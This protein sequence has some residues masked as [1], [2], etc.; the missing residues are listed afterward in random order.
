MKFRSKNMHYIFHREYFDGLELLRDTP[1]QSRIVEERNR[2]VFAFS[3]PHADLFAGMRELKN[4]HAFSLVTTYPGLLIGIGNPHDAKLEGA[5]KL[6]FSLDYVTGLPYIPGSSL[7]GM[8]R[9]RFPGKYTGEEKTEREILLGAYL[10][11]ADLDAGKLETE[12]FDGG[13]IF[14][15][16]FPTD[17]PG[18]GMLSSEYIT[19]H[20]EFQDPNP[21]SMM[22]IRPNVCFT[23]GF[24]LSDGAQIDAAQKCDLFRMLV[25]EAGIGAKTNV[26]FGRLVQTQARPAKNR[27]GY[28]PVQYERMNQLMKQRTQR[29]APPHTPAQS[30]RAPQIRAPQQTRSPQ[31]HR[32][33]QQSRPAQDHRTAQQS[34][35]AR[36]VLGKCPNCGAD[37]VSGNRF[38][39]CTGNCGFRPGR[40]RGYRKTVTDREYRKLL[41]GETVLMRGFESQ[42]GDYDALVRLKGVQPPQTDRN[43]GQTVCYGDYQVERQL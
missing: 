26:G 13:D 24:L 16:V 31:D 23:F 25:M 3:F 22:K 35:P 6:G 41:N 38:P 4:F 19:P 12:I 14:L 33:A 21:I 42:Y 40:P 11:R 18:D 10:K 29:S 1:E 20:Q 8:L 28:D 7:K 2:A 32:T 34:R 30:S 27:I 9:S 17:W 5:V 43:T 15:G 39:S 36:A 37:I